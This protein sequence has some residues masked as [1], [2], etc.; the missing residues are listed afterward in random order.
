VVTLGDNLNGLL[1]EYHKAFQKPRQ[2]HH[3]AVLAAF[4]PIY[5]DQ[6]TVAVDV[7]DLKIANLR[8]AQSGTIGDA[9]RRAY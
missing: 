4:A 5:M 3:L 9:E 2:Q 6:H 8:C 7:S 1:G